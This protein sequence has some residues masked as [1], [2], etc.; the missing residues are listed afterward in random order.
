MIDEKGEVSLVESQRNEFEIVGL[1][2]LLKNK[3]LSRWA[4]IFNTMFIVLSLFYSSRSSYGSFFFYLLLSLL[5]DSFGCTF[6]GEEIDASRHGWIWEYWSIWLC[7]VWG[8]TSSI[9][10]HYHHHSLCTTFLYIRSYCKYPFCNSK[11][12]NA[13]ISHTQKPN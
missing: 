4:I 2:Q 3:T 1:E 9:P 8:K 5:F 12:Y 7:W 13:S 6:H 10:F 11:I